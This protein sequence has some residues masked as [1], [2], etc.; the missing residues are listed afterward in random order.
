MTRIDISGSRVSLRNV[1]KGDAEHLFRWFAD[2]LVT[3]FLPLAGRAIMPMDDILSFTQRASST[4][5]PE[6]ACII[7]LKSGNPIGCGGFRNFMEGRSAEVSLVI[8][9]KDF[10]SQGYGWEAMKLLLDLA[11]T[12]LNLDRVWLVVRKDNSAG[13][14][15][16]QKSGF[17]I[18]AGEDI[19]V[20][21]EGEHVTKHR[22]GLTRDDWAS[23]GMRG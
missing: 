22:M 14:R 3:R 23:R 4:D 11:F 7:T 21:I 12:N 9:E 16:F 15:L 1:S 17:H 6:L 19:H 2:P 5:R 8:G 20:V 13:I 10:W 18:L